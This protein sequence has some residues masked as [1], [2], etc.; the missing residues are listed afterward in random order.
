MATVACRVSLAILSSAFWLACGGDGGSTSTDV[1]DDTVVADSVG[2]DTVVAEDTAVANDTAVA[3]DTAVAD[4]TSQQHG[5]VVIVHTANER[6]WIAGTE[7]VSGIVIG[8]A[9]QLAAD[10]KHDE[11]ARRLTLSSGDSLVGAP[12]STW[13]DGTPAVEVMNALDYDAI[14]LGHHD[15]DLGRDQLASWIDD[16]SF[17]FLAANIT[18][19]S[20]PA[21]FDSDYEIFTVDGVDV[22]VIGVAH[23]GTPEL[24]AGPHYTDVTFAQPEAT[25]A[26]AADAARAEGADA[27]VVLA[28]LSGD[29]L[30]ALATAVSG[31]V[32]VILGGHSGAVT[33]RTVADV[34][35]VES[36]Q[37]WTGYSRVE[38]TVQLTAQPGK[39][40][41]SEAVWQDAGYDPR[42]LPDPDVLALV[43]G[44]KDAMENALGDTIGY[45]G[46]GM[47][48]QSW[49]QANWVTDAWLW[50]L[51]EADIALQNSGGLRAGLTAGAITRAD[52]VT[53]LSYDNSIVQVD[54][55]GAEI[56]AQ[57]TAAVDYCDDACF[58]AVAGIRYG[59]GAEGL[60]VKLADGSPLD[61]AATYTVL[62]NNFMYYGGAGFML[63]AAGREPLETGLN[64]RDPPMQWTEAQ[65]TTAESPLDSLLDATPRNTLD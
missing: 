22:A 24:A 25:V 52:V 62:V 53:V 64:Y 47:L 58:V 17:S 40:V 29:G 63:D 35:I 48:K 38:L 2:A 51:P 44:W 61:V 3:E 6:G 21:M 59:V 37:S 9:A 13:F 5:T 43:N 8:G 42:I 16:A 15:L 19:G 57:L 34:L 4:S 32:D 41:A 54:L 39:V 28:H 56:L 36:G 26:T 1:S 50:A 20:G 30:D 49:T 31:K 18:V 14:A 65:G 33:S 45:L 60:T 10:W 23:P 11:P 12:I 46:Q 55:T 27:I 7:P